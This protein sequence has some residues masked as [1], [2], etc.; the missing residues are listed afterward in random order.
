VSGWRESGSKLPHSKMAARRVEDVATKRRMR[1]GEAAGASSVGDG[2]PR[3]SVRLESG[4]KLP[5]SKMAVRRRQAVGWKSFIVTSK[6]SGTA[7]SLQGKCST[8]LRKDELAFRS[9][10]EAEHQG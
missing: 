2:V 1:R 5:H 6:L 7:I 10:Q 9:N 8:I 3:V 4:S